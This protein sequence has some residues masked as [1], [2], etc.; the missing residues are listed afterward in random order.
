VADDPKLNAATRK[1][2]VSLW[3]DIALIR[4]R[5][6]RGVIHLS[7]HIQKAGGGESDPRQTEASLRKLDEELR[8]QPG[9]R[10]VAFL[11]DN[12]NREP[13]GGWRYIGPK[14]HGSA[15]KK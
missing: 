3:F 2:V 14:M 12:W 6:T 1:L 11:F 4:V 8:A 5:V 10:G 7:G 13:T 9:F 15:S